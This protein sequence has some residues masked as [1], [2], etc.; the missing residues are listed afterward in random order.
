MM[1]DLCDKTYKTKEEMKEKF[2][3]HW[4][5]VTCIIGDGL[6]VPCEDPY[7]SGVVLQINYCP[8]CGRKLG[9]TNGRG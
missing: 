6:Y 9:E 3:S 7:Y 8:V 4:D 1:C 5:E 2:K